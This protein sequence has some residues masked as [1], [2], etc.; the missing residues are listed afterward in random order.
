MKEGFSDAEI[1]ALRE[2]ITTKR[3]REEIERRIKVLREGLHPDLK[4]SELMS[5]GGQKDQNGTPTRCR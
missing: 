4:V 3:R 5:D 1:R 2:W